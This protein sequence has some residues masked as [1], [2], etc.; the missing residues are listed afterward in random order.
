MVSP[1]FPFPFPD[2][3]RSGGII[4][5]ALVILALTAAV[6]GGGAYFTYKLFI[7]PEQ[8]LKQETGMGTPTPP[9]D[10]TIPE[11]QRCLD[12]KNS[13]QWVD[14]RTAYEHFLETYPA[15]TK[16][17]AAKDDLGECNVAIYFSE[18][19]SPDKDAYVIR[20]GDTLA[21][22]ERKLKVPGDEIM[23][24]NNITDPRRLRVGDTL[25]VS[26]PDFSIVIDRKARMVTLY[27]HARFFKQYHPLAWTAPVPKG[28]PPPLTGKVTDVASY[29]NGQR[30]AFGSRDYDDSTHEV[31]ISPSGFTLYTD[32]AEGGEKVSSGIALSASDMDELSALLTRG[33][34]VTIQ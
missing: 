2:S 21:R 1:H 23:R 31:M 16:M 25:Y 34:P 24:M 14:A 30:V 12:L 17:E 3:R 20:P 13:H 18:G 22:I 11:Y 8:N 33:I 28:N 15:S 5:K 29:R 32:P 4:L 26:H 9:P 7:E 6:F 19:A 10:M 27:N